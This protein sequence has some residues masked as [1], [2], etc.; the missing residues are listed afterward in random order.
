M[1]IADGIELNVLSHFWY[2]HRNTEVQIQTAFHTKPFVNRKFLHSIFVLLIVC[3][4]RF[5]IE[6]TVW[7]IKGFVK[8]SIHWKRIFENRNCRQDNIWR[9]VI[10]FSNI[11]NPLLNRQCQKSAL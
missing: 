3:L 11:W 10:W 4:T 6:N 5:T 7:N 2:R 9:I 8:Y 1:Q